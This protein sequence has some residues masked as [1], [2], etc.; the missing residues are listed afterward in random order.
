LAWYREVFC[1]N[2]GFEYVGR[3]ITGLLLS[4]NKTLQGICD[5]QVWPKGQAV[6]RRARHAA[7]FEASRD[8][9]GLRPRHR[10]VVALLHQSRNLEVIGLD[11]TARQPRIYSMT[12]SSFISTGDLCAYAL[13]FRKLHIALRLEGTLCIP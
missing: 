9:E 12:R 1:R 10:A 13:Q 2:A 8:N 6:N 5:R 4:A 7:V 3:Y 11:W